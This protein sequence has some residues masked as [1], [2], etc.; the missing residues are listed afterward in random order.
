MA[1]GDLLAVK[2]TVPANTPTVFQPA[3]G[4]EYIIFHIIQSYYGYI[5]QMYDGVTAWALGGPL[6]SWEMLVAYGYYG[7]PNQVVYQ[8]L[9]LAITNSVY[10]RF[11][12]YSS[13]MYSYVLGVQTK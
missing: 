11:P 8:Q 3:S 13:T 2:I 5:P 1:A 4:V 10:L 9:R 12:A 7:A 6:T